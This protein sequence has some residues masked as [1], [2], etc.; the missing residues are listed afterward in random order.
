MSKLK[1][2]DV[3]KRVEDMVVVI[4]EQKS[5]FKFKKIEARFSCR[6]GVSF[7]VFSNG[8]TETF[9]YET[10]AVDFYNNIDLSWWN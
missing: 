9:H 6:H 4:D 2:E 1:A 10:Y 7:D 3:K 5:A 8:I